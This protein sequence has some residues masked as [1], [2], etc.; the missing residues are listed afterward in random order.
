MIIQRSIL[1]VASQSPY[2]TY[3][4]GAYDVFEKLKGIKEIGFSV[5][6]VITTKFDIDKSDQDYLKQFVDNLY[7]IDRKNRLLDFFSTKP[8]QYTSRLKLKD[9][10]LDKIYD[11][12][13]LES[14]FL[15]SIL[16][17]KKLKY[18]KLLFRVHNDESYYFK[19]LANSTNNYAKKIYYWSDALKT[20]NITEKLLKQ[21]DRIWYI[22]KKEYKESKYQN[23][24]IFLPPPINESFIKSESKNNTILFIGSLFMENNIQGLDWFLEKIHPE[25]VKENNDYQLIIA[26]STGG[27]NA[28]KIENKYGNLEKVQLHLNKPSLDEIYNK[29]N[30]FINPMF[31]GSGVK[32]KSINAIVK[33]SLLLS[34]DVGIEGIGLTEE[35][36]IKANNKD[37]FLIA[38]RKIFNMSVS[39]RQDI[40]NKAQDYLKS[41]HYLKILRQELDE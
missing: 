15:Y 2:P 12:V 17:N 9:V 27:I 28:S 14:E 35:M 24:A 34:T 3:H 16:L 6:L 10:N 11:Y 18:K 25:I 8:I 32:L 37:E 31:Y 29:A 38:I 26:G 5:D 19:Q 23:K 33:G 41:I 7:I 4:G 39:E 36:Y 20:Q 21:S 1:I 30:I 40:I 22:S 13:L